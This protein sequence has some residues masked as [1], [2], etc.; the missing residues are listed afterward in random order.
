MQLNTD[1]VV[2]EHD[3]KFW[4]NY[5][6]ATLEMRQ[7]EYIVFGESPED[8]QVDIST[9]TQITILKNKLI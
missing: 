3:I 5:L 6:E 1:E 2:K 7:H 8:T 9:Q 4:I